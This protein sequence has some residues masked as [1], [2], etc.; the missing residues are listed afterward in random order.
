MGKGRNAGIALIILGVAMI[1]IGALTGTSD[2]GKVDKLYSRMTA[3]QSTNSGVNVGANASAERIW[4]CGKQDPI[5]VGRKL[6]DVLRPQAYRES[7]GSAFLR[8]NSKLFIVQNSGIGTE[9]VITQEDLGGRYSGGHFIYLGPGF[10][11]SSPAGGSGGS[12]GSF[13]GAK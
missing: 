13:G 8:T 7:Q 2:E 11:P 12:A 4:S 1:I 5:E 9:C 6:K 10:G 3:Q